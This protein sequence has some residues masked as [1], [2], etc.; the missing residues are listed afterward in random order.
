MSVY[1]GIDL[2]TTNSAVATVRGTEPVILP[3]FEGGRIV[4]SVVAFDAKTTLVGFPAKRQAVTNPLN[5]IFSVK[6]LM[7]RLYDEMRADLPRLPYQVTKNGDEQARVFV[8]ARKKNLL[9]AEISAILLRKLREVAVHQCESEDVRAVISVP[10]YFNDCQRQATRQAGRLAGMRVERLI[11]EPTAAALAYGFGK[12]KQ[13]VIAVFDLGGGTFDISILRVTGGRFQVLATNGDTHLGGDDF[14]QAL[15]EHVTREF[16][17]REAVA[18]DRDP[19]AMQR[20]KEAVER[21]KCELSSALESEINLPFI[22]RKDDSPKHLHIRVTRATF[23]HLIVPLLQRIENPC[24]EALEDAGL[25]RRNVDEVLLVGGSTRIPAVQQLVRNIFGAE[26]RKGVSPEEVVAQGAAIQA[27]VLA[28]AI[29]GV[30]L[31]DI[32]PLSIGIETEGGLMAKVV[33]RGTAIPASRGATFTTS[34]DYQSVVEFNVVQGERALA[35]D[36]RT[37]G[38]FY[39]D[40]VQPQPRGTVQINVDFAVDDS[41]ILSVTAKTTPHGAARSLRFEKTHG[42]SA[43]E[44]QRMDRDARRFEAEDRLTAAVVS[45]RNAAD[46][47]LLRTAAALQCVGDELP[48]PNRAAVSDALSRLQNARELDDRKKLSGEIE[49]LTLASRQLFRLYAAAG[50]AAS[51]V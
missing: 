8:P 6:R 28:G 45:L 43:E 16:A 44:L 27:A 12:R 33:G 29:E 40:S 41:G 22:A 17:A 11:N 50:C 1:V 24:A 10:A 21:S 34:K 35:R 30:D 7:G 38:R 32:V 20:L 25:S 39:L 4:P 42:L 14:D 51:S 19:V 15:I 46:F 23:E 13:G 37:I 31:F 49:S 26:P 18:I 48:E 5:T 9:P 36:N 2:G 47:L 3:D